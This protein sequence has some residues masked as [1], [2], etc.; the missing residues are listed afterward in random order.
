MSLGETLPESLPKTLAEAL[1][2][3]LPKTGGESP[4]YEGVIATES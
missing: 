4:P 3:R 2:K 1:L